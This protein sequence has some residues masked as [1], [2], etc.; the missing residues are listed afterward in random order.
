VGIRH[1]TTLLA[2]DAS[3]THDINVQRLHDGPRLGVNAPMRRFILQLS[4]TPAP[5]AN[6]IQHLPPRRLGTRLVTC[7]RYYRQIQQRFNR[8]VLTC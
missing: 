2:V 7:S 5:V 1:H 6:D 3:C 8:C 4:Q